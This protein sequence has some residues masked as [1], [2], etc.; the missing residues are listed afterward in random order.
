MQLPPGLLSLLTQAEEFT[1][2]L[3]LTQEQILETDNHEKAVEHRNNALKAGKKVSIKEESKVSEIAGIEKPNSKRKSN[4]K[5][6]QQAVVESTETRV[7]F[8]SI[9]IRQP[10]ILKYG[11]LQPHQFDSLKWMASLYENKMNGIL[12]D[13]MGL[14]KTVQTI[15]LFCYLWESKNQRSDP[16]LVVA[17]KSTISNWMLEFSRWAPHFKTVNLNPKMEFRDDII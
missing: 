4:I 12:A 5:T 14:G 7:N 3:L 1:S 10:K 2:R 15:A 17:T 9:Y 6:D 16:Y 11:T 8:A 13:D